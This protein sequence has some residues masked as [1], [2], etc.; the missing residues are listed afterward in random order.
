LDDLFTKKMNARIPER[1]SISGRLHGNYV[2]QISWP[3]HIA[4]FDVVDLNSTRVK[5]FRAQLPNGF[6]FAI[7]DKRTT[8][9]LGCDA[10]LLVHDASSPEVIERDLAEGR[11]KWI[12]PSVYRPS[13]LTLP[14][15]SSL[16]EAVRA[17]WHGTFHLCG[18][19][20]DGET[21]IQSG[22]RPPQVGAIYAVKAHWS[23]SS[24]AA[25]LVMPTGT[26]KTE[27]MLSLLVSERIPRLL[28]I[29]PKDQLRS[30]IAAKFVGHGVLKLC[31]CLETKA[32]HP[33]VTM[34]RHSPKSIAQVDDIFL[35]SHVIV[36]TM[37]V[38][39]SLPAELKA[40]IAEHVS[41]LFVDE[42]HHIG[43]STWRD[44]KAYFARR[45]VLQF[46]A[47]PFRNDGRHIDGKFI[48]V[49]PLRKA[50]EDRLFRPVRY[51]PV[52]GIDDD[53]TDN[54]II[55]RVAEQ[56]EADRLAGFD[57]LVMARTSSVDRAI[58][59]HQKY[60]KSLPQHAPQLIHS[61]MSSSL[62][63]AAL[64]ALRARVSRIIV[65]V[66]MLG[67]GFDLPDLKI[68]ALHDKHRSEAVTLQFI[69][70]FTRARSDL[71]DAT[72]IANVTVDDVNERLRALYAEDADWNRLL[73][74]IG[75]TRIEH[76]RKREDL[77][78]GF[79][80]QPEQFPL[81]AFEPRMS[82]VV[83]KTTCTAWKPEA[84]GDALSSSSTIVEGP[85]INQQARVVVFVT[86]DQERLRWTRVRQPQNIEYNMFMA[87]WDDDAGLLYINSSR[88]GDLHTELAQKI[89][90]D[91]VVR[92]SGEPIFRVLHGFWRLVLM[93]LGLSE[94]QR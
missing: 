87:H 21:L 13:Q 6:T 90:G 53:E 5:G 30:Q 43:A 88:L 38:L 36:S 17:S 19:A 10:V 27:T 89:A 12:Y 33:I 66:D 59:L 83:Y 15:I 73:N 26:G 25:T 47:T 75:H 41:H 24:A 51:L 81:E 65:C 93:N 77:F 3:E 61:K 23:V 57:H 40:R 58:A 49:Y 82:A 79:P 4:G 35:F 31:G 8:S 80:D 16:H 63:S 71:G 1:V 62:R 2:R 56:I 20:F 44:F 42:A 22:L 54:L 76:E 78:V 92:I 29:V 50:Q 70:R 84:V 37:Q 34:L 68:A 46:T 85:F 64:A 11:G 55:A 86:R 91:D 69:G 39:S 52:N 74:V 45:H 72:V 14:Q 67:E 48:Y 94:T 28:V 9:A 32:Q 60:S 7:V 18:E